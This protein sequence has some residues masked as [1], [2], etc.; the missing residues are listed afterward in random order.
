M[1]VFVASLVAHA[2]RLANISLLIIYRGGQWE[3]PKRG[4]WTHR[5]GVWGSSVALTYTLDCAP[6]VYLSIGAVIPFH[7]FEASS[8]LVE[9]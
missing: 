8:K 1:N 6:S 4:L 5:L 9:Q 3:F 2:K 7:I